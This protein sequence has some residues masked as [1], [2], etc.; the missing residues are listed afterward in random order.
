M[1]DCAGNTLLWNGEVFGGGVPVPAGENDTDAVFT[2]LRQRGDSASVP[3]VLGSIEGPWACIFWEASSRS[4]WF[5]RDSMGRRSLLLGRAPDGGQGWVLASVVPPCCQGWEW[6]EL[7][8]SGIF[9]LQLA[10]EGFSVRTEHGNSMGLL[11]HHAWP[12][13][14]AR[15]T[16]RPADSEP[17][18]GAPPPTVLAG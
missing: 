14:P 9:Q 15:A 2:A 12:C 6:C 18:A 13:S 3:S 11:M 10:A 1:S 7:P 16:V 4:L 8:P 5:G 17:S